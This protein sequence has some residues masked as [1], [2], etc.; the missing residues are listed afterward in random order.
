M[1]GLST[2]GKEYGWDGQK[3]KQV[4]EFQTVGLSIDE[5]PKFLRIPQPNFMK[6]DVDGIE[7]LILS[8]AKNILSRVDGL[9]TE[10]NDDFSEQVDQ[11]KK[12]L[13][14]AG[15]ELKDKRHAEMFNSPKSFGGRRVW[16]Q[17]W[18]RC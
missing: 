1:G 12:L 15:L 7:H 11:C 18:V 10:V 9:L 8:G 4:F 13:I 17:I 16:N 14:Q 3:I 5:I 6:I 2:F